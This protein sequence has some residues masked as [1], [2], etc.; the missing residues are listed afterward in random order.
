MLFVISFLP[1]S[2]YFGASLWNVPC[3]VDDKCNV[4]N[5]KETKTKRCWLMLILN[6]K[7]LSLLNTILS[8]PSAFHF[9]LSKAS[10]ISKFK[11]NTWWTSMR[12]FSIFNPHLHVTWKENRFSTTHF[13]GC[14]RRFKAAMTA[15]DTG[16]NVRPVCAPAACG[17]A[18]PSEAP[19]PG[20]RHTERC[21]CDS[22]SRE[23]WSWP[24]ECRVCYK[25]KTVNTW[26]TTSWY[27]YQCSIMYDNTS[28]C[29]STSSWQFSPL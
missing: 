10:L 29:S 11:G 15:G 25:N 28:D 12:F 1:S 26:I 8:F 27:I 19:A 7:Q 5:P 6:Q 22:G 16:R 13:L 4:L 24:Q 20:T 23:W 14:M 18:D 9:H 2:R 17:S 3:S 21:F